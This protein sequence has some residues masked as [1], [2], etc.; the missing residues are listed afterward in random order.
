MFG[1][2]KHTVSIYKIF[3]K[4]EFYSQVLIKKKDMIGTIR[5]VQ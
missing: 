4:M 5:L 1:Q 2:E 3:L